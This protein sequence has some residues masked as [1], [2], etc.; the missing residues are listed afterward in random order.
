ME[1]C[2]LQAK[3]IIRTVGIII[4]PAVLNDF[5]INILGADGAYIDGYRCRQI[6]ADRITVKP[7]TIGG[8]IIMRILKASSADF[9]TSSLI[10]FNFTV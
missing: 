4:P 2:N 10:T 1:F 8:S 6:L 7:R 5:T 9:V 3:Q